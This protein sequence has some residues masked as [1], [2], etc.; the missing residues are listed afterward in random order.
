[1]KLVI[2]LLAAV[3]ATSANATSLKRP[4][5]Y[6]S[7]IN[8][9]G[10]QTLQKLLNEKPD[11]GVVYSPISA[12]LA[13]GLLANAGNSQTAEEI[14]LTLDLS[15]DEMNANNAAVQRLMADLNSR[16]EGELKISLANG[17]WA[18][19]S[20]T[21][22]KNYVEAMKQSYQAEVASLQSAA[23]VNKWAAAKTNN[24]I[25]K[26]VDEDVVAGLEM[27]LANATYF[28]AD[29]N[30]TFDKAYPGKFKNSGGKSVDAQLMYVKGNFNYAQTQDYQTVEL[31]YGPSELASMIIVLPNDGVASADFNKQLSYNWFVGVETAL[32]QK[33]EK[34][35]GT[36]TMP[37]FTIKTEWGMNKALQE[38]G[39]VKAFTNAA[40]F[41][42][43]TDTPVK[44]SYVKQ[45]AVVK[46][47]EKGTEAAAVTSIGIEA[48]S[49]PM[50]DFQLRVD[51]PFY[52]FIRDN[53][54]G[55]LLF[56]GYV[57]EPK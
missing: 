39:M 19:P 38:L 37:K 28:K 46:V 35:R 8:T 9:F 13:L 14:A 45:D 53:K 48:T 29:W 50:Y 15:S 25:T 11:M 27:M 55:I 42:N 18:K 22:K 43:M 7:S 47:D 16:P 56:A 34:S 31:P 24:L 44:V 32:N 36:V 3:V 41:S 6:K 51:R 12:H 26:I 20:V 4:V 5:S 49:V 57:S 33:R 2:A 54:T 1:M 52:Y 17:V 10:M 30:K 21:L 40:D 23:Q